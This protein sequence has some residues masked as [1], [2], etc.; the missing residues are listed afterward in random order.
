MSDLLSE[1]ILNTAVVEELPWQAEPQDV[2]APIAQ[3]PFSMF[4]DSS[5]TVHTPGR[6]SILVC[7]PFE[8]LSLN[9]RANPNPFE[10][11]RTRM[12]RF[13]IP[14]HWHAELAERLQNQPPPFL[15]G[16]VG[17]FGYEL[18][19]CLESLPNMPRNRH[20]ADMVVG[21]YDSLLA[22][23]HHAKRVFSISTG[24]R[25]SE[26]AARENLSR[27]WAERWRTRMAHAARA[28]HKRNSANLPPARVIHWRSNF[29]R[30][31]YEAAVARIVRYIRAGDIFQANLSRRFELHLDSDDPAFAFYRRLRKISPAPFSAFLNLGKRTILSSSPERFL[32]SRDGHVR[33]QPI[34]GT[35]PRGTS[36]KHD[37]AN[38]TD[39][40]N[41]AKDR[42]ENIMIADLLRN[43]ISK[44]ALPHSVGVANLCTLKQ[45]ANVHHLV[46]T[47]TGKLRDKFDSLDL[48]AACFP[49]GSITGAPKPRAMEIISELE[50]IER[51]AYCG[52]I[53]YIGF[54]GSMDASIAIRTISMFGNIANF[55]VGGGVVLD[56]NPSGEYEETVAK[57]WAMAQALSDEAERVFT[58]EKVTQ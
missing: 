33:A 17:L 41:S 30:A 48:L 1:T 42:A 47:V 53:G 32:E 46:S 20:H 13:R 31:S 16:A 29:T 34:K 35:R 45:F 4:L 18:A 6:W 7:E 52:A 55:H 10:A 40:L 3:H 44:V 36:P 21:L 51:G 50:G 57:G 28:K 25:E 38:A 49:G 26:G 15:G 12:S 56:S 58:S 54:D 11:L 27:Y 43:D 8:T 14:P 5:D 9:V 39:L 22:F 37:R 19:A 23:D 24:L 2:F